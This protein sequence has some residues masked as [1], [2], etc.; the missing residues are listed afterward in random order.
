MNTGAIKDIRD[1]RD[2]QYK[3]VARA[4]QPFDWGVGFDIE[5]KVGKIPSKDQNGSFS[6]GGQDWSYYVGVLE[7]LHTNSYEDRSAKFIYA[8]TFYPSGGSTGRDNCDVCIKQG[9]PLEA[10]C[11]SYENGNPPSES[12]MTRPQDITEEARKNAKL[13]RSLSYANVAP[14]IDLMAQAIRDNGGI[15]IGIQGEDNGTWRSEFPK[16]AKNWQWAHWLYAGKAKMIKGKKYIGVKNSW[17]NVGKDGWQWIGEDHFKT[18]N[19][20]YGWTMV[21]KTIVDDQYIFT[22][23]MKRGDRSEDV[24]QLQIRLGMPEELQTG[25]YWDKTQAAVFEWQKQNL[26]LSAYE[27]YVLR[28]SKF[29][30][31]SRAVINQ[32]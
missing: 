3:D 13:S 22:R 1:E 31:K 7:A 21:F 27:R 20:W 10:L 25:Y 19:V 9:V 32:K 28:G 4:S 23:D 30:P 12:F 29:G 15:S 26:T 2:F 5:D 11:P 18:N 17:G 16:A 24:K 8:Q 14:N 6:C